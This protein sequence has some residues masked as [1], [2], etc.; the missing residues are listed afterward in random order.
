MRLLTAVVLSLFTVLASASSLNDFFAEEVTFN[1]EIPTP[2]AILGYPVG[3]WHVRHDQ[4]VEYMRVLAEKSNRMQLKTIGY[5]HEQRPLLNLIV[6][7]P[8][9]FERLEGIRQ[10]HLARLSGAKQTASENPLVMYMGYSV[11]G[12]EASGSNAA[13]LFAYYLA[14]AEGEVID[15]YLDEMVI[16]VDPSLN[17]DGLSRFSHWVNSNKGKI[18]NTDSY[19]RMHNEAWPNGRTNHYWFDLNRD[20]LLLVHPESQARIERFHQWK[21]NVVTDFHE[22][23]SHSTYFFQPGIPSRKNPM[24]P[25]R[26]VEL[27]KAIAEYHAKAFDNQNVLYFTEESYDDFYAGKGSTYPDLNG[28][29]GILFEQASARGFARD[30]INGKL[31]FETAIKNQLTASLSTLAGSSATKQELLSHQQTFYTDYKKLADKDD[32]SGYI[33]SESHDKSRFNALLRLLKAHQISAYPLVKDIKANN[34]VFDKEHSYYVP[35]DQPQYR[36]IRSMFS[37]RQTF[38]DNTFYD[39]SNWNLAWSFNID[40]EPITSDWGLKYG[41]TSW[42]EPAPVR[43]MNLRDAYAYAF[44]WNDANSAKLLQHLLNE[45]LEVRVA[46]KAFTA[47]TD[48]GAKRFSPGAI[49]VAKGLQTRDDWLEVIRTGRDKTMVPVVAIH[50]GLS[51]SG[52][53]LG[54]RSMYPVRKPKVLLLGGNGVSGYETGEIWHYLDTELGISPTI[55]E[56]SRLGRVDLSDYTHIIMANGQYGAIKE[57]TTDKIKRWVRSG[58][59]I[60]G[61]K[62]G[63]RWLIDADILK[64]TYTSAKEMA[65]RFE[66]AELSYGDQSMVQGKQRIAGAVFSV[67]L[68]LTHPLA[69]GFHNKTL[70]VFKNSTMLIDKTSKPFITVGSYTKFPQLGGYAAKENVERIALSS[71]MQA[72]S[73]GRGAVV[74]VADNVNFRGIW[75]GTRRLMSNSLYFGAVIDASAD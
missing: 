21:P 5:S 47:A 45:E 73:L 28:S 4:L 16:I 19:T 68:D 23:G 3:K 7:R 35:L 6:T 12:N 51:G 64:A 40:F 18:E 37:R 20:W 61:Q 74:G 66:K 50:S 13:L 57:S 9:R 59:V 41:T 44:S 75:Q 70:P 58:G 43:M 15:K 32:I 33:L 65:K 46:T 24:T 53:D 31:T 63:A 48:G 69:Y 55:V 72:H 1:P 42:Q 17:P 67:E 22:M 29:V 54:S 10:N 30:T 25:L 8:D 39:V 14:A 36:L 2:E 34:K 38:E 49:V 71:F 52:I 62:G 56:L 60:W 27:T 11:H 26:N